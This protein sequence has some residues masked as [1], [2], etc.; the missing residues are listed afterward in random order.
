M[1]NKMLEM[2][3]KLDR[4]MAIKE[5]IRVLEEEL[6][7]SK[8]DL[9]ADMRDSMMDELSSKYGKC[10][11]MN[12]TRGTL[13]GE[14]TQKAL[15]SAKHNVDVSLDDCKQYTDCS[16]IMCKGYADTII[17]TLDEFDK[18]YEL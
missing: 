8:T 16:F 9:R 3:R 10:Y 2:K 7:R 11:Y 1:E 5:S 17:P 4:I 6:D 15:Q 12:Y 18:N 14:K 13:N